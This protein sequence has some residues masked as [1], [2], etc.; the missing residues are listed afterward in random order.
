MGFLGEFDFCFL[1]GIRSFTAQQLLALS[2][3]RNL[4]RL[5]L[6]SAMPEK[7]WLKRDWKDD[8]IFDL[9]QPDLETMKMRVAVVCKIKFRQSKQGEYG[10][11]VAGALA[12]DADAFKLKANAYLALLTQKFED[13]SPNWAA[14]V[15]VLRFA[16]VCRVPPPIPA[17]LHLEL[18][19]AKHDSGRKRQ[20]LLDHR[21]RLHVRVGCARHAVEQ[22]LHRLVLGQVR[23]RLVGSSVGA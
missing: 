18:T 7:S 14:E 11:P 2:S 17:S 19:M 21:Q 12:L 8:D 5:S 10:L 6:L 3:L 9:S 20:H 22:G 16:M 1:H 15:I 4:C 13:R 23:D